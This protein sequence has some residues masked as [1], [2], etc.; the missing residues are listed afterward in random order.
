MPSS[1]GEA[2]LLV[3]SGILGIYCE[4]IW[5][6]RLLPFF[7]GCALAALGVAGLARMPLSGLGLCGIA[8][9]LSLFLI[10]AFSRFNLLPGLGAIISLSIGSSLLVQAP[11]RIPIVLA[12][13]VSIVFGCLTLFLLYAAKQARRSKWSDLN[14]QR[15]IRELLASR[16]VE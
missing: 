13:L 12:V 1:A 7:G 3:L 10:E 11:A 8:S 15:N 4:F 14:S 9:A 16:G 2:F 6:G 5:P